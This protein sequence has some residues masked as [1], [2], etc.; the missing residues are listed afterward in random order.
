MGAQHGC[1]NEDAPRSY[2]AVTIWRPTSNSETREVRGT[3]RYYRDR[4]RECASGAGF[5]NDANATAL[6]P[7]RFR[8]DDDLYVLT[9]PGQETHQTFAREI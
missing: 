5:L 8:L 7:S 3:A 4:S 1:R 6:T 9:E 2:E